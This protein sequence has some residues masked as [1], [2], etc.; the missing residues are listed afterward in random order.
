MFLFIVSNSNNTSRASIISNEVDVRQACVAVKAS[1]S[2]SFFESLSM[3]DNEDDYD[4]P[5]GSARVL[6]WLGAC[7]STFRVLFPSE[8]T[9]AKREFWILCDSDALVDGGWAAQVSSAMDDC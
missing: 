7:T 3:D 8:R 4:G 1:T 6:V 2:A 9:A 5:P